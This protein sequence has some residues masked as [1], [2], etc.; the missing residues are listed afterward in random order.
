M[1]DFPQRKNSW[2]KQETRAK[3]QNWLAVFVTIVLIFAII[4]GVTKSLSIG[5]FLG[6]S[7]WDGN[8]SVSA[9]L[10]TDPP[11][12]LVYQSYPKHLMLFTLD[13]NANF[14][15]G[16]ISVPLS[17]VGSV[18]E[19]RDGR[20]MKNTVAKIV[21]AP[22]T[23]FVLFANRQR[24]DKSS[25]ENQFK[26]FAS[27]T[28]PFAVLT[29]GVKAG[30]DFTQKDLVRLWWQVKSMSADDIEVIATG[31]LHEDIV[32]S[33][34]QKV[35]G[36]DDISFNALLSKYLENRRILEAGE[37]V[38]V[39]NASGVPGAGKLAA[40][41]VSSV[42]GTIDKVESADVPTKKSLIMA[43][44]SYSSN[45]LAKLFECDITSGTNS[46]KDTVTI[47]VGRDFASKYSL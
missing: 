8:S 3:W 41:F 13:A 39:V 45:Y 34:G 20:E 28:T 5:K 42:G 18:F 12:I 22:I 44:K 46:N 36:V 30:T 15:T 1:T 17:S 31:G 21:H 2:K 9:V 23:N 33:S 11:S 29:K 6:N 19:T 27:F 38:V 35:L 25:F 7:T 43:Q 10:N 14:A 32:L 37:K 40:E 16:V 4:S 26:Q 47:I 24:I